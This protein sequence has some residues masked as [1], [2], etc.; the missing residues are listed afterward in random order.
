M[1]QDL[2]NIIQ[3]LHKQNDLLGKARFEYL[4]QEAERK[5]FEA[6]LVRDT[7]GKSHAERLTLA[8]GSEVWLGFHKKLA[9][10]ESE[11][12][13][14]KLKFQVLE[15]EFLAVHLTLKLDAETIR[16]G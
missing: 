15:K 14:Q 10:L 7:M 8:Q 4:T 6:T 13:F 16:K 3:M 11:F 12:E 2:R 1:D 5:H 9:R